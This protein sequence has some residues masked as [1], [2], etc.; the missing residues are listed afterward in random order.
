MCAKINDSDIYFLLDTGAELTVIPTS[1][2]NKIELSLSQENIIANGAGGGNI[3][4][5]KTEPTILCIGPHEVETKIWV[6]QTTQPLLGL[7]VLLKFNSSLSFEDGKARWNVR[8]LGKTDLQWHSIWSEDKDD[9]GLLQMTPVSFTGRT[10]PSTKQYPVSKES[11]QGILPI[12]QQLEKRGIL[13]KTQSAS[14][15][16]TWPVRKANG[17]WRLT[18][19]YREANKCVDKLTPLVANP[20]TIFNTLKPEH[21]W[22]TVIDMANG[23]W[24][25]PLAAECQPWLAF[26]VDGQQYQWTRLPQ[27]FHNSP[28]V[29]HQALRT[30]LTSPEMPNVTSEV[31]QY[32]DDVLIT[33]ETAQEHEK[34]V[35]ALLDHLSSKGH[36]ASLEKAQIMQKQVIYLG[37]KI[38]K[39]ERTITQDRT[40]AIKETPEPTTVQE[41]RKFL[42]LCNYNRSW[43]DSYTEIAQPLY[44]LLKGNPHSKENITL[45]E[46]ACTAFQ[47][48]KNALSEAPAIGIPDTGRPFTMFV[49]EKDGYMTAMLTQEHGGEQ[50]PVGYYS[51][52]LDNVALGFGPC[53]RAVQAVYLAV[54][55]VSSLT[56][57]QKLIVKCPHTVHAL[58]TM[59][60]ASQVTASRWGN[61]LAVLEASNIVIEKASVSN[62]STMMMAAETNEDDHK[63]E[64]IVTTLETDQHI[65]E[66]PL[67][68]PDLVLFTDGSS[69]CEMGVRKAG[70]AVTSDTEVLAKGS[71]PPGTSAQQ[72][73]LK[74]LI[75]ACKLA[76]DKTANIYTDS[77]YG[78]GVVHDFGQLWRQRGFMTAAGT[79]VKNGQLVKELLEALQL[80]NEI[81]IL[82]VKAHTKDT[83]TEAK[84]NALADCA[85]KHA[86]KER[87]VETV[88]LRQMGKDKQTISDIKEMQS[89]SPREEIWSWM[90]NGAKLND[91]NIWRYDTRTVAPECLLPYLATQI[92]SLGH[93]GDDKMI[94]RFNQVWWNPKFRIQ[95]RHVTRNCIT[96]EKNNPGARIQTP[97]V[98]TPAPPGPFR[99][100]Q[101][102]YITL[103]RCGRFQD[104]LVI[105]DKYTRWV[106]A[107][108]TKHGTSTHT[109]KILV[110]DII[111]RWGLPECI[112]SDQG[113]HFTAAVCKEVCRMLNIQWS[114]HCPYRPQASGQTER[115]NRI[116]KERLSKCHQEGIAWPDALPTV[117]CSIRATHNKETGLSPFEI[118]TGRPMSLPGT[119][120]L[121]KA[122]VHLT[123]DS[124]V[125]YCERLSLAVQ[126]AEKQVREAWEP[127]PEGG[128]SLIPGQW[129][130]IHK[131][132]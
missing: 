13:K 53:L 66:T 104:V 77:R 10:P 5:R 103:P 30:H 114:L 74:A 43:V 120:D 124:L 70:W 36:K 64:E 9:C 96:C 81:T 91:D 60:R 78:F 127:P 80:P 14:N 40:K 85:A 112:D 58:L 55:L 90:E 119:I 75:E 94:H 132:Q 95:A 76:Q 62:P 1:L 109:A 68:N 106:E 63:C 52:K 71:M 69:T 61:W 31:I 56:L 118:I 16:P 73:E 107:F 28:T 32:V 123:S 128:H 25:V 130:M 117:L 87:S 51:A 45:T 131:P 24:S 59:H 101:M 97:A 35:R 108:P 23:F 84:G 42:G 88:L 65:K 122:D 54:G 38:S 46:E 47:K 86:S 48:L 37:Q 116:I 93:V 3:T 57:D 15:S 113:T 129:V 79:P 111:P 102:D 7:D 67:Q 41:L 100:L 49:N 22:F 12:V 34:D 110:K 44:D 39:G 98:A 8:R 125:Q 21:E 17:T 6:G 83:T 20:A 18:V 82:K 2:T 26:T 29:Y 50:R 105:I 19:D 4:L 33:S 27:G 99:H 126:G 11:I 92:H 121:R 115:M 89:K 72:A